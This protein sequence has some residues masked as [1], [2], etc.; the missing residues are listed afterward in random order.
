MEDMKVKRIISKRE[1][2]ETFKTVNPTVGAYKFE[3]LEEIISVADLL[4]PSIKVYGLNDNWWRVY[5]NA[6]YSEIEW[7]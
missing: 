5:V 2:Y 1:L 7:Y 3:P 4:Q 6:K